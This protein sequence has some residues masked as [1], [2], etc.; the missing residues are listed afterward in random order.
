MKYEIA[1]LSLSGNTEKLAYG[2]A[3]ELPSNETIITDLSNEELSGQA[4]ICLLCFGAD[5]G[6]VPV[7]I[8]DALDELE[9][10]TI[11]LF[12]TSGIEPTEEY[13]SSVE[14]KVSPF[15]P[16]ECDYRGMFMCR[17]KFPDNVLSAAK[18]KLAEEPDNRYA[19]KILSDAETSAN[20]PN[21]DDYKNAYRFITEHI[22]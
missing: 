9:N 12:I 19:R 21:K 15:L 13:I 6:T 20:H 16:D 1:Y 11:M 2:I 22:G 18:Q 10:K 3:D 8:M 17:S 4:E 7:K 5:K 14:N